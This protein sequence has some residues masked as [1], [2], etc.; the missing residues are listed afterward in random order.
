MNAAV[1][2]YIDSHSLIRT[3]RIPRR[4]RGNHASAL[5]GSYGSRNS[6][7]HTGDRYQWGR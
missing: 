2:R 3:R 4:F 5:Y 1:W 6:P 7:I